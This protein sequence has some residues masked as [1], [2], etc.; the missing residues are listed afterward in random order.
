MVS[1]T[2]EVLGIGPRRDT[3]NAVSKG[4]YMNNTPENDAPMKPTASLPAKSRITLKLN[5]AA[6]PLDVAPWT[7]CA[8]T[9]I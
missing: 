3:A 4:V 5:G 2:S 1:F 9:W 8:S 7:P 6:K